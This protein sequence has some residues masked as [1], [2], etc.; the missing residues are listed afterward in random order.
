TACPEQAGSS[1][2]KVATL[3]LAGQLQ[4]TAVRARRATHARR[5][6]AIGES[7]QAVV[8]EYSPLRLR[9]RRGQRAHRRRRK[10]DP[11][12]AGSRNPA[13]LRMELRRA[14]DGEVGLGKTWGQPRGAVEK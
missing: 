14:S 4:T 11:P 7:R 9:R 1:A 3:S 8:R 13:P 5:A 2:R 6:K 10:R 12:S